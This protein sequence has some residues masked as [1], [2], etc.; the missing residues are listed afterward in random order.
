VKIDWDYY[1]KFMDVNMNGAILCTRA[2]YRSM[3]ERGGGS[4]VNQSSTAAWMAMGF[5][6][7]AKLGLN[8][9]T[10]S[11][12]R[13]LGRWNIRVNAIAPGPTDTEAA[14]GVVPDF[15]L[16]SILAQMPLNR[17]GKPEDLVGTLIFL[18][19]D[20]SAWLTGQIINVDGGQIMRP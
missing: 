16:E 1:Q 18:L 5:Y 17:Q 15:A 9:I 14:R 6:G 8:G 3:R 12:A 2:C 10:Q 4:I 11:L 7:I 20:A 19:S 13:E